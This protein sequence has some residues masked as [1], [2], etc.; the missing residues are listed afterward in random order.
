MR[1]YTSAVHVIPM[2][3]ELDRVL[4]G[5]KEFPTNHVVLLYGKDA[6]SP[7]EIKAR[8]NGER[9]KEL[10]S[11]TID[12]EEMVLDIFD[13]YSATRS[14]KELF[15]ELGNRGG[16]VFVNLSTGNRIITSAALLAAFMTRSHP[17][18]VQPERYSI[19]EDQEVLSHGVSSVMEIPSVTIMGPSKQ[20]EEV[21]KVIGRLGGTARHETSLIPHLEMV[22][23]FFKPRKDDESKRSYLARNRAHLSRTLRSLESDRYITLTKKGRFVNVSLTETGM[24]FSGPPEKVPS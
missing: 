6:R 18:Y 3:L 7:I 21:L 13:F 5:L 8:H 23:G 19:P 12:V 4:G 9:V 15:S 11:A 22:K 24:L 10:I 1:S 2:G 14:L 20:Q 16:E 17:Y